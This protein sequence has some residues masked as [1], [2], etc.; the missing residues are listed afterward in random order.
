MIMKYPKQAIRNLSIES[1][2]QYKEELDRTKELSLFNKH[3]IQLAALNNPDFHGS[4]KLYKESY[5]RDIR[6]APSVHV[7]N[8]LALEI[9]TDLKIIEDSSEFS[10]QERLIKKIKLLRDTIQPEQIIHIEER[11]DIWWGDTLK[12]INLRVGYVD[13]DKSKCYPFKIGGNQAMGCAGGNTGEGKSVV[14]DA[15]IT[16]LL[17]E[18]PPWELQIY[19]A[20]MKKQEHAK[21]VQINKPPQIRDV[22][23]T[24]SAEYVAS[25]L[26]FI[27]EEMTLLGNLGSICGVNTLPA[28]RTMLDLYI[29][30]TILVADEYSQ[31]NA[32]G[33]VKVQIRAANKLQSIAK[34]GRSMHV[35]LLPTSQIFSGAIESG[36]LGQ[37]KVGICVGAGA[38]NSSN[39][40]GNNGAVALTEKV[41]YCIVNQ[42]RVLGDVKNNIEYKVAFGDIEN[43]EGNLLFQEILERPCD[44]AKKLGITKV[45][46]VFNETDQTSYKKL[47]EDWNTIMNPDD[48]NDDFPKL[49]RLIL[50]YST[51]Y[52]GAPISRPA[53]VDLEF[54]KNSN[55]FIHS[56]VKEDTKYLLK[57]VAKS[58]ELS[59]ET[60]KHKISTKM[61]IDNRN[62]FFKEIM[63]DYKKD[64]TGQLDVI[65]LCQ[66]AIERESFLRFS[67]DCKSNEIEF[68][69]YNYL[70]YLKK[71]GML[72][73]LSN[74]QN[75]L[76]KQLSEVSEDTINLIRLT[77]ESDDDLKNLQ[78]DNLN[79]FKVL[80]TIKCLNEFLEAFDVYNKYIKYK[81]GEY[82][83]P[84]NFPVRIMFLFDPQENDGIMNS[85]GFKDEFLRFLTI[86]PTV[87]YFSVICISEPKSI[88]SLLAKC[89]I[90]LTGK[91]APSLDNT[92]LIDFKDETGINLKY[93]DFGGDDRNDR[94]FKKYLYKDDEIFTDL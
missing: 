34:K 54:S 20:D 50:G 58:L 87:G 93:T 10:T 70:I 57:L 42:N 41:G 48:F 85:Y 22:G 83:E 6:V 11:P 43:E 32:N 88:S 73:L 2:K 17:T 15:I 80:D 45:P 63:K 4:N 47:I 90:V 82:L 7:M 65:G 79:P 33:S 71:K 66:S 86:G 67:L 21:Y 91:I 61:I 16:S 19:L 9:S 31:L 51:V 60:L 1:V 37:F 24:G 53:F 44:L 75:E 18:Y 94:Y 25:M 84:Y 14:M 52:T 68:N 59:S 27:D 56:T 72:P 81:K 12:G 77:I 8:K 78:E 28:L 30:S 49:A 23:V 92:G 55:I 74:K 3:L 39:I 69:F 40:L 64:M 29:P 36:T 89:K 26:E 76:I 13:N 5:P 38:D 46:T 35:H 62:L